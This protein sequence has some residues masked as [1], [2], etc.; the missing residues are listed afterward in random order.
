[1]A[2][3]YNLAGSS[4]SVVNGQLVPNIRVGNIFPRPMSATGPGGFGV[5]A[6]PP[7]TSG[8][9]VSLGSIG[10]GSSSVAGVSSGNVAS[11]TN[12]PWNPAKSPVPW[13][14][15]FFIGGYLLLRYVHHGY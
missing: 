6:F 9:G 13:L 11:A 15:G 8:P 14:L 12:S 1:M 7:Q 2:G 3:S 5:P 10:G 4:S